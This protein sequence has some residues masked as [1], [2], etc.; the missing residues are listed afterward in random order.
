MQ[1][2]S[3]DIQLTGH[4]W[5]LGV[6]GSKDLE[7]IVANLQSLAAMRPQNCGGRGRPASPNSTS[8]APPITS[9][10]RKE[11]PFYFR[12]SS[13]RTGPTTP[14]SFFTVIQQTTLAC[15]LCAVQL[16]AMNLPGDV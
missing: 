13:I 16:A 1:R 14:S 6:G 3:L 11:I 4:R 15:C 9:T 8:T 12:Q 10:Y 7:E 2:I 5:G